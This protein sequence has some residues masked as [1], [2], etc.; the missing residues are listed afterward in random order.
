MRGGKANMNPTVVVPKPV[1]GLLITLLPS[2]LL[3]CP[4]CDSARRQGEHEA[5][6]RGTKDCL[7][8]VDNINCCRHCC[9]HVLTVTVPGGKA[10]MKP[11]VV[12][13]KPV[14]DLLITLL[15]S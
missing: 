1:H 3:S 2:L 5:D 8:S 15:P 9:C 10:N 4:D 12:A 13:P 6:S 14:Y 11:T 7:R